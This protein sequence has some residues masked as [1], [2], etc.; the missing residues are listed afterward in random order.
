M[1]DKFAWAGAKGEY[2][3]LFENRAFRRRRFAIIS[4]GGNP[5]MVAIERNS[6]LQ[7]IRSRQ[8]ETLTRRRV[9]CNHTVVRRLFKSALNTFLENPESVF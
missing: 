8:D 1:L 9:V 4:G 6:D 5:I 2:T 3:K 7:A